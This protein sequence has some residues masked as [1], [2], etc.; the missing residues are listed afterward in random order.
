MLLGRDVHRVVTTGKSMKARIIVGADGPSSFVA[1]SVGLQP[2][3]RLQLGLQVD[4]PMKSNRRHTVDY[5]KTV[6]FDWGSIHSGYGWGFPRHNSLSVGVKAPLK[7]AQDLKGYHAAFFH[8]KGLHMGDSHVFGQIMSHR[9]GTKSISRERI[10][11]VG[12]AAGLTDFW[13]GEGIFYALRSSQIAADHIRRFLNGDSTALMD[14]E[15]DINQSITP[16]LRTAYFFC[17]IFNYLSRVAFK[18]IEKYAYPTDLFFRIMRG[19]R[20]FLETRHRL[21]PDIFLTKL[22]IKNK[23]AQ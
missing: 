14:Y 13:T 16:E 3:D 7:F 11:L 22:F 4:V 9:I 23:R 2:F 12:D 20:T 18:L 1:S 8:R 5:G 6:S 19:D 15:R 17:L 10:L 21:R